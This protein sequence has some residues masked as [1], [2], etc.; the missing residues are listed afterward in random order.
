MGFEARCAANGKSQAEMCVELCAGLDKLTDLESTVRATVV[1]QLQ[2]SLGS[3]LRIGSQ[4]QGRN[5][6]ERRDGQ[7]ASSSPSV[8]AMGSE[9]LASTLQTNL[10]ALREKLK[11]VESASAYAFSENSGDHSW[12]K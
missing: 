7:V 9:A 12:R 5:T 3:Q 1:E 4:D 10:Q 8:A 6:E 2:R 11:N